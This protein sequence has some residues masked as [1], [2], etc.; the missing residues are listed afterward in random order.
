M[1]Q[2]TAYVAFDDRKRKLVAAILRPDARDSVWARRRP[3]ET[4]GSP[5]QVRSRAMKMV[6]GGSTTSAPGL[7]PVLVPATES[8]VSR[9][10]LARSLLHSGL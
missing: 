1:E 9:C 3:Q 8:H 6:D 7:V 10:S 4:R 2:D 5:E